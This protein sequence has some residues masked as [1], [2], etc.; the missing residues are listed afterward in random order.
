MKHEKIVFKPR[1]VKKLVR[2]ISSFFVYKDKLTH[3]LKN[4]FFD[5]N[6]QT[7]LKLTIIHNE[8]SWE[9]KIMK[10][11]VFHIIP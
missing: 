7:I 8:V 6:E 11:V 10:F 3:A 2:K 4:L 9:I 5:A 1:I